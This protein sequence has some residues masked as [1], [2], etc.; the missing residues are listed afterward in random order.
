MF[1]IFYFL[2]LLLGNLRMPYKDVRD[3]VL[4]VDDRITEQTMEQLL[5]YMPK[6]EEV[7]TCIV[8]SSWGFQMT[9]L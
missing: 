1:S 5:K 8:S 3:L 7:I 6:K 2:A 4:A 9:S